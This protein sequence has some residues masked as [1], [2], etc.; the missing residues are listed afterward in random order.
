[1]AQQPSTVVLYH[2]D[3][4]D[5]FSAAWAAWKKLKDKAVYIPVPPNNREVPAIAEGKLVYTLDCSFPADTI[6]AIKKRVAALVV[7]DHHIS[8]KKAATRATDSLFDIT[9]SGAVLAWKYFHGRARV[10][11]LLRHVEDQDLWHFRLAHTR[12][13]TAA[14]SLYD[15]NMRTWDVLVHDMEKPARAKKYIFEGDVLLRQMHRRVG[16]MVAHAEQIE[17]EGYQCLMVNSP[18]L[19]SEV[20]HALV[21]KGSPVAI[22]WSRRDNK[23]YVSLRSNGKVDVAKLAER[24]GGGGHKAAAGFSFEVHNF[25]QFKRKQV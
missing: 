17:F 11:Q 15:M 20:G 9:H 21:Q 22:V 6:L 8:N 1:M 2:A 18:S 4:L 7:I 16:R 12:E 24:Y 3:C 10:P 19:T 23:I 5:G 14:L 25:L 13:V